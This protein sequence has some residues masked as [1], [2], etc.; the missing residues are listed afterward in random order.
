MPPDGTPNFAE[1]VVFRRFRFARPGAF[2]DVG[3]NAGEFVDVF[4]DRGWEVLAFEPHP[5]LYADL[6][7]RFR[8]YVDVECVRR[9]IADAPG[10]LPFYTSVD[11]PGI[12]SLAPF[13][14]THLPTDTV[15]VSTLST[16]LAEHGISSV[17]ALKIDIEG[18]D[19]LALR[20]LDLTRWRPELVMIEF[21]DE[22]SQVHFDWSHHDAA[23]FMS[24]RGYEAWISEWA[25]VVDFGTSSGASPHRW[26][27]FHPYDPYGAPSHGNMLFVEAGNARR[28]RTAVWLARWEVAARARLRTV[29]WLRR[30]LLGARD[31][32]RSDDHL[33]PSPND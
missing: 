29:P 30:A 4:A 27:G 1:E 6:H 14:H 7:N 12:H 26:L 19:L 24:E 9:A 18:A 23:S 33:A 10:A 32:L 25:P 16:E 20:G 17:A 28:L 21:M 8:S 5:D 22:R 11:H 3:A 2:V 31:R 15:Q 13:H